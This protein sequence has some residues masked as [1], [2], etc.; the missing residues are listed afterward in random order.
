M[1]NAY[2]KEAN[3]YVYGL[4]TA[5]YKQTKQKKHNCTYFTDIFIHT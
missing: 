5:I 4:L 3:K 1:N 2:G